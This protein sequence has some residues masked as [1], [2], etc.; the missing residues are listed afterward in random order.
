MVNALNVQQEQF[1]S[2]INVLSVMWQF[3]IVLNVH[4]QQQKENQFVQNVILHMC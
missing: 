4:I 3:Q 1:F 2:T